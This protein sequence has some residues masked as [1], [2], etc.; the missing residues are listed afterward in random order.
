MT[1][2]SA[3]NESV[4]LRSARPEEVLDE[5]PPHL[6]LLIFVSYIDTCAQESNVIID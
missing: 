5:S 3:M 1:K 2:F 6:L 4:I